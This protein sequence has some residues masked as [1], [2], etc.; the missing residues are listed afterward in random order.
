MKSL[1]PFYLF[2]L[3]DL[4]GYLDEKYN[5]V[6]IVDFERDTVTY[7][8]FLLINADESIMLSKSKERVSR[9]C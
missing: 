5:N 9:K 1:N 6:P 8:L 7:Y 2:N 3:N 4:Y